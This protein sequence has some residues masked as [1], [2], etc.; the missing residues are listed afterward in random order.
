MSSAASTDAVVNLTATAAE[1]IRALL[2]RAPENAGKH[3]RLYVEAGGCSGMKYG[4]VFDEKRERDLT[5][6]A[7]GVAVLVD[8]VSAEYLRGAVVDYSDDLN[9]GGFKI[10]NPQA[11]QSCG[12]GRSFE[13]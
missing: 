2:A 4:M 1:Q 3:L 9:G 7:H 12:C 11:R 6:E 13:A 8:A 5:T 10:T